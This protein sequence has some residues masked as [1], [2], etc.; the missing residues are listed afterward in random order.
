MRIRFVF[1]DADMVLNVA[2]GEPGSEVLRWSFS[3]DVDWKP[4]LELE[5]D[6]AVANGYLQERESL[7]V[8]IARGKVKCRGEAKIALL[9]LP[10]LRLITA[11]YRRVVAEGYPR[12]ALD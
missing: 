5:M 11:P 4:K 12:L 8:A 6:S 1:S 10:T 9:Y 2:A 3:G 7:A